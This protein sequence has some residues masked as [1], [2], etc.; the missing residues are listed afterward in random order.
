M[1]VLKDA[2]RGVSGSWRI[3]MDQ[4]FC[5]TFKSPDNLTVMKVTY[6]DW[7]GLHKL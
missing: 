2:S 7:N 3:K 1:S 6:I 5:N 4:E